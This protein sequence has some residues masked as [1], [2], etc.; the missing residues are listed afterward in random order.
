MQFRYLIAEERTGIRDWLYDMYVL[1][2][3]GEENADEWADNK[4]LESLARRSTPSLRRCE[5]DSADAASE[6]LRLWLGD[7]LFNHIDVMHD[8]CEH[9]QELFERLEVDD[10]KVADELAQWRDQRATGMA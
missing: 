5:K 9:L 10:A 6:R 1:Q 8:A 7:M 3:A 2:G 4:H